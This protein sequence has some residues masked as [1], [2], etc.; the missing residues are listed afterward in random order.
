MFRMYQ[1][2]WLQTVHDLITVGKEMPEAIAQADLLIEALRVRRKP[3]R[4]LPAEMEAFV[5]QVKNLLAP[6]TDAAQGAFI[7]QQALIIARS[8]GPNLAQ[9]KLLAI[10]QF[11]NQT[12]LS[13]RESVGIIDAT[14]D[15]LQGSG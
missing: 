11:R 2:A 1:K 14:R 4:K 12:S 7:A 13:L 3:K 8:F 15:F 6:E 5:A 10:K 9:N